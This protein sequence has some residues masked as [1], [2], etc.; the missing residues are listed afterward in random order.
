MWRELRSEETGP[1][2]ETIFSRSRSRA[3]TDAWYGEQPNT[4]FFGGYV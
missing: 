4:L 2:K 1:V 3:E